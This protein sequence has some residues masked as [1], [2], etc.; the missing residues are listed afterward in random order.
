MIGPDQIVARH[1]RLLQE[2]SAG[3]LAA[4]FL[5]EDIRSC[6]RVV[7]KI[8]E[9]HQEKLLLHQF[10]VAKTINHAR[11]SRP[12]E[13][14]RLDD[15][16]H[17]I[18]M[19]YVAGE[20]LDAL[21][22][23]AAL[24]TEQALAV[25]ESVADMLAAAHASDI[26]HRDIKP[27]NVLIP[28]QSGEPDFHDARLLDFGVAGVLLPDSRAT[29][30]GEVFGTP[31]YMS[32][33][34]IVGKPQTT[35][36]DVYGLGTLLYVML[37]RRPP[38]EGNVA[39]VLYGIRAVEITIPAVPKL[40]AEL[41]SFLLRC[42]NKKP[43]ERPRNG[44]EALALIR[45][46]RASQKQPTDIPTWRHAD[47]PPASAARSPSMPVMTVVASLVVIGFTVAFIVIV[48]ARVLHVTGG[49]LL[50]VLIVVAGIVLAWAARQWLR[51]QQTKTARDTGAVLLGAKSRGDLTRSLALQVEELVEQC[52]HL[53]E[54][55]LGVTVAVLF[56]EYR[57][58]R[59]SA[60][61]QAALMNAVAVLEKLTARLSPWYVR[62]Q[63]MLAFAI[64]L[65]GVVTGGVQ[66]TKS[67]VELVR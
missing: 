54:R 47:R 8:A 62:Y 14:G 40:P 55:I 23:R 26:I 11:M 49:V 31:Q 34:Q 30:V 21:I 15:G 38:F 60:N 41:R 52:R 24:S 18:V 59:D 27:C 42:L 12:L 17:F 63:N 39:A 1:Y 61:R 53:D 58:A 4:V 6:Q 20:S 50:G 51:K 65:I 46:L 33:E 19:E 22:E 2:L 57:K 7:L 37:F 66:I 29:V 16:R 28:V 13:S 5:A 25:L 3:P 45:R 56:E 43:S 36:T 10:E 32:P 67:I 44:A 9:P 64:S 48:P 35:A